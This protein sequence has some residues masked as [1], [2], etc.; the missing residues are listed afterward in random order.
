MTSIPGREK[1][2]FGWAC[3]LLA[4]FIP[5]YSLIV[6]PERFST[7]FLIFATAACTSAGLALTG[8]KGGNGDGPAP[9]DGD[10][11]DP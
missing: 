2:V 10:D 4:G 6:D 8:E 3:F 11:D 5:L 7:N 1:R 9:G